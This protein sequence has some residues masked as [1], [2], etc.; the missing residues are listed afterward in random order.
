MRILANGVHLG[1]P[2]WDHLDA[3]GA[4]ADSAFAVLVEETFALVEA[5]RKA[6][7]A[8]PKPKGKR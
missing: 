7:A 4:N 1:A 8:K 5:D 2:L 3:L 6:E